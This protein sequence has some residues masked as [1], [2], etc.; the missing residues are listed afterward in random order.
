MEKEMKI[1]LG[2]KSPR[3][4]ELLKQIGVSFE[5]VV[6][7]KEEII[8]D[9]DPETVVRDLSAGKAED[10]C[11]RI[12]E[13]YSGEET[14]IIGADTIV[15][16]NNRILG[17]PAGKEEAFETLKMLQGKKHQVY[18]GVSLI[19]LRD[20]GDAETGFG[21]TECT[22]V[23][24]KE[25]TD[26]AIRDYI[27]TGEPMDKAGAYAIQGLF[28]VNI[29][30]ISGDYNNVVGLPVAR[31]YSEARERLGID[32]V[33]GKRIMKA[34]IFD[35]DGTIM[36]TLTSIA[37]TANQVL[38]E[39][40]LKPHPEENYKTYAGDGQIE[41]IKRALE[42]AGDT[43][44]KMF[45]Q[46]MAR[47]IELF[48]TGCTYEVRPYPEI[49]ELLEELKKNNIKIAVFSNKEHDN[50]CSI[51]RELFGEGYFDFILGQRPDHEKKPNSGGIDIILRAMDVDSNQCLY[52]GDTSTD[53][54][55]GTGASLFTV[56]V[57]WGFREEKELR[58]S[59]A[60]TIIHHPLELLQYI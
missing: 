40:G 53:M 30:K 8:T 44:R 7:G 60:H 36:D 12:R 42:A 47:Y 5:C 18:T 48:K 3:R 21:F 2:S 1:I 11:A 29:E 37:V 27:D 38:K 13:R 51:L 39:L 25:M 57:T 49:R 54:K 41:L 23:Y 15:A 32:I 45:D 50:V 58:D 26:Q 6:S 28:A 10:V 35:L 34:C 46:A 22:D 20:G 52:I 56:G 16:Y 19:Y 4:Q 59:G 55:T 31:I 9:T 17:K 14:L 24:M 33:T 43:G